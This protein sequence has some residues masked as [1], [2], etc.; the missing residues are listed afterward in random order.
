MCTHFG[1]SAC[2]FIISPRQTK[3]PK[4]KINGK[5]PL[6]KRSRAHALCMHSIN[7]RRTHFTT[8]FH[9]ASKTKTA[10]VWFSCPKYVSRCFARERM[11][12][13]MA[14]HVKWRI[15]IPSSFPHAQQMHI[16][17]KS[18]ADK[19]L[20]LFQAVIKCHIV[21]CR[22]RR[23][24]VQ[25]MNITQIQRARNSDNGTGFENQHISV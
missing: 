13:F 9:N 20:L 21:R 7:H 4:R 11:Y 2:A 22:R 6:P 1:C 10:P 17:H 5:I 19:S 24:R 23:C 12:L 16:M 25:L 18:Q 15:S 3:I 14:L 8:S